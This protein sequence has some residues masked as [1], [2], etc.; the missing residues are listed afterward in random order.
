MK[1][2][3]LLRGLS[4]PRH[5]THVTARSSALQLVVGLLAI[6]CLATAAD[7]GN[8]VQELNG[9]S[10]TILENK[11]IIER[12]YKDLLGRPPDPAGMQA[13]LDY[14]IQHGKGEE[15][16]RESISRSAEAKKYRRQR[17]LEVSV[18]VSKVLLPLLLLVAAIVCRYVLR[19][20]G[21]RAGP[22]EGP[23]GPIADKTGK[24]PLAARIADGSI[25]GVSWVLFFVM[26]YQVYVR[27]SIH[28]SAEDPGLWFFFSSDTVGF[29][30]LYEDIFING[31]KWSGWHISNAPQYV[32]MVLYFL[33]RLV[34]GDVPAA[35]M[36]NAVLLPL[37]LI[38][39]MEYAACSVLPGVSLRH[40][41]LVVLSGALIVF[42]F[43][44]D[45]ASVLIA[46]FWVCRHAEVV[47]LSMLC[48]GLLVRSSA[49][50]GVWTIAVLLACN[51][52]AVISDPLFLAAFTAPGVLA[53]LF[54]WAIRILHGRRPI[55][56]AI[57]IAAS[58]FAGRL[59]GPWLAPRDTVGAFLHVRP[60]EMQQAFRV[61]VSDIR[62][63]PPPELWI[64]VAVALLLVVGSVVVF[65]FLLTRKQP[66]N[67]TTRLVLYSVL[68]VFSSV[69][70][71]ASL[72][73]T[74]NTMHV[75]H[76]RYLLPVMTI[77]FL[78]IPLYVSAALRKWCPRFA[79]IPVYVALPVL[80]LLAVV[81]WQ[82]MPEGIRSVVDFYPPVT[83][84]LDSHADEYGLSHGISDYW[85]AG[86]NMMFSRKG[87]RIYSVRN[88]LRP[89]PIVNNIDWYLGDPD[90]K[91]Y[92]EPEYNFVIVGEIAG[93][94]DCLTEAT[95]TNAFGAPAAAIEHGDYNILIYNRPED[96]ALRFH[97]KQYRDILQ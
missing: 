24:K 19:R 39:G 15:W 49:G 70:V 23:P 37:L 69:A 46:Y 57:G 55:M 78:A 68:T 76:M 71:V 11:Q 94:A 8:D 97:F 36:L 54:M 60:N 28:L 30:S 67:A 72:V 41:S 29:A 84:C 43:A 65:R 17:R 34:G 6:A 22:P 20:I 66:G 58:A 9:S 40:R 91:R 56:L 80:L 31:F 21:V 62:Q 88:D 79:G 63:S 61:L 51:C 42:L 32:G 33:C 14:M 83:Q 92:G 2:L 96:T 95:V 18:S 35:H 38:A 53:L 81:C 1:S 90:A 52:M 27:L 50:R 85:L 25:Y 16:L 7:A 59:I 44:H 45:M 77:P 10:N 47:I 74:G 5:S 75:G 12:V 48:T 26:M 13:H 86:Y 4:A 87:L 89:Y 73:L 82:K 64:S 93:K 3:I